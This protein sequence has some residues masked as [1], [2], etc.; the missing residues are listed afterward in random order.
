MIEDGG[1]AYPGIQGESGYGNSTS[2]QTLNGQSWINHNQGMTLR[3]W[4]AGQAL[5]GMLSMEGLQ[6]KIGDRLLTL[7][8]VA[9][10]AYDYADRMI[11]ARKE[12]S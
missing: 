7:D 4:F 8:D 5:A 3:D 2:Y 6:Q 12:K 11:Q 9:A 10:A 1:S